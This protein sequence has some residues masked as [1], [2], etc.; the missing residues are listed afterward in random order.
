LNS[1]PLTAASL[2]GNVVLVDFWTYSCINC[3][4]SLPYVRAWWNTY[5]D[6]GLTIVGV[7]T[8]EFA[9]EKDLGN[10][11]KAVADLNVAY[12]VVLDNGYAIWNAFNNEYWPAHYLIDTQGHIRYHH[13]GEGDY[14]ETESAIRTLL[15]QRDGVNAVRATRVAA[16]G[17][18]LQ[19]DEADMQSPETYLGSA[20]T[21]GFTGLRVRPNL[22]LNHWALNGKW[23]IEQ[24]RITLNEAPGSIAFRFHARDA[25]LVLGPASSQSIRFRVTIDGKAPGADAGVD[26]DANGYGMVREHRL[27]QLVRQ[28]GAIA[29]RTLTIEFFDPGVQAYA[30]AFG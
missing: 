10:V 28:K 20:R 19:A 4:R 17:V 6:Q 14:D 26:V 21:R 8:P 2:R 5:H 27:Y 12:P 16:S 3:L 30:F 15:A 1:P 24:E 29:D 18:G 25:H 11:R 22:E 9:F 13:F 23:T 7:H